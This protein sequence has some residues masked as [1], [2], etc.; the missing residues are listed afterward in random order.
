MGR[1]HEQIKRVAIDMSKAFLKGVAESLPSAAIH[2]DPF[3]VMKLCGEACDKVRK[4][5]GSEGWR[6]TQ[7]RPLESP[8]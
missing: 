6:A 4:E 3:Y 2:F 5:V 7:R 8:W 1:S